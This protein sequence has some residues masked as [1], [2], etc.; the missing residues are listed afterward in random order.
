MIYLLGVIFLLMVGVVDAQ[1]TQEAPMVRITIEQ[2]EIFRDEL[3]DVSKQVIVHWEIPVYGYTPTMNLVFEQI[4][5][6]GRIVHIEIPR[7][8]QFITPTGSTRI[9]PV[10]PDNA[11]D[12]IEL[13]VRLTETFIYTGLDETGVNFLETHTF[14]LPISDTSSTS[15]APTDIVVNQFSITPTS[16]VGGDTFSVNW[17]VTGANAVRISMRYVGYT[18]ISPPVSDGTGYSLPPLY[19]NSGSAWLVAPD[20]VQTFEVIFSASKSVDEDVELERITLSLTCRIAWF[21]EDDDYC[22][23]DDPQ[24]IQATY[25]TFENGYLIMPALDFGL[26]WVPILIYF[27]DT[28]TLHFTLIKDSGAYTMSDETPPNGL[29]QPTGIFGHVWLTGLSDM[30]LRDR[31][32][33]ATV[34]EHDYTMTYQ[35]TAW[36][37]LNIYAGGNGRYSRMTARPRHLLMFDLP[38]GMIISGVI[39]LP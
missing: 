31:L 3:I 38:N 4:L 25:Q 9:T 32:G 26:D 11:V 19:P 8:E 29:F 36:G 2:T 16:G 28:Q 23:A 13:R 24:S 14:F 7:T 37:V 15:D 17:D 30:S 5:P 6:D 12:E 20:T 27:E 10:N 33:W 22:P 35:R 18:D 39:D 34:E 21:G 1:P